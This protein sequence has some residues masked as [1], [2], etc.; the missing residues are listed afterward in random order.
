M[1][2][3]H[4]H[5]LPGLDDGPATLAEAVALARLAVADGITTSVVTPHIHPGRYD[6]HLEKI[7]VYLRAYRLALAQQGIPLELRLGAEVRLCLESLELVELDQVQIG[8]ASCRER[9]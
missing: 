8:R 3:M 5:L 4:C 2:D 1:I 9:V 7:E 6:N